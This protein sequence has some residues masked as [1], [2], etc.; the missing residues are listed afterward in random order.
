MLN[1]PKYRFFILILALIL[2]FQ[3]D[4]YSQ[5]IG[6]K[7]PGDLRKIE[8]PFE[9]LNNLIVVNAKLSNSFPMKLIVDSGVATTILTEK[10][11]CD[12]LKIPITSYISLPALGGE[13]YISVGIASNVSLSL[14]GIYGAGLTFLVLEEDYLDLKDYLGANVQGIIGYDLIKHFV[15]KINYADKYISFIDPG[16]FKPPSRFTSIPIELE[17]N[18]PYIIT[19]VEINDSVSLQAK[20]MV[21]LGASHSLLFNLRSDSCITVPE[22][23]LPTVVGRGLGGDIDGNVSRIKSITISDFSFSSVIASFTNEYHGI[24]TIIPNS[25]GTIGSEIL[26]RFTVILDYR[27]KML[28]LKKNYTYKRPFNYNQSGIELIAQGMELNEFKIVRIIENSPAQKV[29]IREGDILLS[30]NAI[31]AEDLDL[32]YIYHTLRKRSGKKIWLKLE[33]DGYIIKK[34]FRLQDMI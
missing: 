8:I 17:N 31:N 1:I 11:L 16:F 18:K 23:N 7:I 30:L 12:L 2:S 24:D 29:D 32:N 25:N 15:V 4:T 26:N 33:R 10:V 9:M 14:P 19:S 28:Y 22:N 27:N 3:P 6:F 21:D 13:G 5:Q 34:K 20:L